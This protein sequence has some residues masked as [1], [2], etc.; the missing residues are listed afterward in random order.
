[1]HQDGLVVVATP[2]EVVDLTIK[3]ECL[4]VDSCRH[5]AVAVA[6]VLLVSV[7]AHAAHNSS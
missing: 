3:V 5:V 1:M 4:E 2:H 6:I 7:G